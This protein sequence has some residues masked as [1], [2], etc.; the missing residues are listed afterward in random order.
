MRAFT[1]SRLAFFALIFD[2]LDVRIGTLLTCNLADASRF[3]CGGEKLSVYGAL[4]LRDAGH[5]FLEYSSGTCGGGDFISGVFAGNRDSSPS[6]RGRRVLADI[7]E[8]FEKRTARCSVDD[9]HWV[10][11]AM[12]PAHRLTY[13]S[14]GD[15]G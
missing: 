10:V 6:C 1:F 5:G 12:A 9:L 8:Y 3:G 4:L 2:E 11:V 15:G 14:D 7:L 13:F